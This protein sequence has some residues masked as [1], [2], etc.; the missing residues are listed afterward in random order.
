MFRHQKPDLLLDLT[1]VNGRIE[2][3]RIGACAAWMFVTIVSVLVAGVL[4]ARR[5]RTGSAAVLVP[6]ASDEVG[7]DAGA[8]SSAAARTTV[9]PVH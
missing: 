2:R 8:T 4:A 3:V 7:R 6:D 5:A 9:V 1:F